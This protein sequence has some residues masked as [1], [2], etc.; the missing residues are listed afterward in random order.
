METNSDALNHSRSTLGDF[1]VKA[2]VAAHLLTADAGAAERATVEGIN[3]LN[4]DADSGDD[5]LLKVLTAAIQSIPAAPIISVER[6]E[7][8]TYLPIELRRVLMLPRSSRHCY[9]LHMLVG[10]R[11]ADCARILHLQPH[12]VSE[13]LLA[14]YGFLSNLDV[15]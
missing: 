14:A 3:S 7:H 12:Q 8:R 13:H 5:L 11:L 15:K 4:C 2:F 1:A 9:V 10:L 6:E